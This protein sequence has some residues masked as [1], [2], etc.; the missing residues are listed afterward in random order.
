MSGPPSV[1]RLLV[2]VVIVAALMVGLARWAGRGAGTG[3]GGD[4]PPPDPPGGIGDA[5]PG[6]MSVPGDLTFYKTLG[7]GRPVLPPTDGLPPG[8]N[9]DDAGRLSP[10]QA[11]GGRGAYVVQALATRDPAAARRLRARL[12]ARGFPAVVQEDRTGPVVIYRVRAARYRTRAEAE[13]ALLVLRRDH[14]TAWI[15]QEEK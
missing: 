2:Q 1:R 9:N 8:T 4:T 10:P 11:P 3:G 13:A 5:G 7:S 15:L 6:T 12:A 14:L